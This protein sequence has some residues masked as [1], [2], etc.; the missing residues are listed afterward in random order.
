MGHDDGRG[1]DGD[2]DHCSGWLIT[3][4]E[5][6]RLLLYILDDVVCACM[7]CVCVCVGGGGGSS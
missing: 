1:D 4:M 7:W 2:D 6:R 5:R 3:I